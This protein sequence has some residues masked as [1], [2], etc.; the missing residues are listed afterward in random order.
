MHVAATG[1]VFVF[2]DNSI[3]QVDTVG[4]AI[5]NTV[6]VDISQPT[7]A[8]FNEDT[9]KLLVGFRNNNDIIEFHTK[10]NLTT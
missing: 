10:G 5:I 9:G 8:Y 6:S 3:S 7:S 1:Q 2:G 4:T